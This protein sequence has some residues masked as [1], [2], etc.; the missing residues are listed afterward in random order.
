MPNA[1]CTMYKSLRDTLILRYPARMYP[2]FDLSKPTLS[3]VA[4]LTAVSLYSQTPDTL[5]HDTLRT[6]VISATRLPASAGE[7]A[8][9]LSTLNRNILRNAQAQLSLAESLNA[10][11]GVFTQGDANF[12]QDLRISIRGFGARAGFGIR[13]IKLLLDGIPESA[14]DGQGQVDN[15]DLAVI[16]RVEV[17]RGA[18]GGLWGN[19]SGGVLSL[20]T[21]AIPA[22]KGQYFAE[23][24]FA[25]GSFGFTQLHAKAGA[26]WNKAGVLFSLTRQQIDGY[27]AQSAMQT[28][29]ANAKAAW[30]P[31]SS[32]TLTL[33]LNFTDSPLAG[34]PGALNAEQTAAD[35]R[36][37]NPNN[38]KFNAG[39]S[40]TQGRAALVF[41]KKW[42]EGQSL[43][44]RSYASGRD[45]ENRLPFQN[46]GQVA[47]RRFFAGGGGQYEWAARSAPLRLS[48]GFDLD[49]QA[50]QR[51]RFQ[52]MDGERGAQNL[53]QTE[54]FAGLGFYALAQW[55]PLH[56]LTASGGLRYDAVLLLVDDHFL[57]DGDQSGRQWYRRASPW[58]GLLL[59]LKPG[60]RWYA[61][62]TT[63][64]ETPT[65]T[66]LSNNP[67][68]T[69][70]FSAGLLPQ[71]TLSV[72]TGLRGTS[73]RLEWEC[74][75]F[76]ARTRDELSPYEIPGQP[77]RTYY[78]NAG[79]VL[80]QGIELSLACFPFRGLRL[81]GTYAYSDFK[82][83]QYTTPAGDF[84]GKRLPVL[85]QHSG[86]AELRWQHA[87]G[88][89][90]QSGARMTG[91]VFADDANA[92]A[93]D[94]WASL[95]LRAGWR[96]HFQSMSL[97]LFAGTDN[98]GDARYFNNIRPNAAAGRY[99]EPA[100]GRSWLA[101][102][103]LR[104][105]EE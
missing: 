68:G 44:L 8:L 3:V 86:Y 35:R 38:V 21:D 43:R 84:A 78:R 79:R 25:A 18:S 57:S 100:A 28:T 70:G 65:L 20:E 2:V 15:I 33:L 31:D 92:A 32:T 62:A 89:F 41:E 98:A 88:L 91:R 11:P 16:N 83:E 74:A 103:T 40:L 72:E 60:L 39:E 71:R 69:G 101:G 82:F 105:G 50:D 17:L 76:R 5:R 9:A 14:P 51:E 30:Y 87:S 29:L 22:E 6:A 26:R 85:P 27:R 63:N 90:V 93:V 49:R 81:L 102:V 94:R 66:E 42:R 36:A 55:K 56:R 67:A 73:G 97:E 80:R 96:K 46:G 7:S 45:F 75:L 37:A 61:N 52:N 95:N 59:R 77:G 104:F 54:L 64:F 10:A 1:Q 58:A 24:R 99:Y 12:S 53:D 4:L 47:F 48:A 34:D 23:T 19:A 13:G